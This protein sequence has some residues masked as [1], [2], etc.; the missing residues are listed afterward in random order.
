MPFISFL[1]TIPLL[2]SVPA[3]RQKVM[4]EWIYSPSTVSTKM[5]KILFASRRSDM[6]AGHFPQCIHPLSFVRKSCKTVK[7]FFGQAEIS[8]VSFLPIISKKQSAI[9]DKDISRRSSM[10]GNRRLFPP[11]IAQKRK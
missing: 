8:I 3:V 1:S 9:Q 5:G 2:P 6:P 7:A 10:Q 4:P 11:D